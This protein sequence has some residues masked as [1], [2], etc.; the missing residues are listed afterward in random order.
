MKKNQSKP[1]NTI[2]NYIFLYIVFAVVSTCSIFNKL[3]AGHPMLSVKFLFFYGMNLFVLAVYAFL[4][5][6]V[7]KRFELSVAYANRPVVTLLEMLWGVLLF[8]EKMT[9]NMALGAVI[10][11]AGIWVVVTEHDE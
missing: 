8:N 2:T 11:A 9:W 3:A 1:Y 7:L 10:I 5:Q 4:W 6:R